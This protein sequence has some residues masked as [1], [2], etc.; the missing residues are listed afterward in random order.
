MK[1]LPA[2]PISKADGLLQLQKRGWILV[3]ATYQP[4]NKMSPAKRNAVILSDYSLLLADLDELIP[5]RAAPVV[6]MK[7]NI[8]DL[9]EQRLISDRFRVLNQGRRIPFPVMHHT[10]QFHRDFAELVPRAI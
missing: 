7:A 1:Q 10:A 5:D 9:L 4:V 3:D 2:A 6:L 8:C